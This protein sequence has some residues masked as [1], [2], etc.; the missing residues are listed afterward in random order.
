MRQFQQIVFDGFVYGTD[1]VYSDAAYNDLVGSVNQ[2]GIHA[3]ASEIS[4]TSPTLTVDVETSSNQ[5]NWHSKF[6][7]SKPINA[8][9][10]TAATGRSHYG[11]D[12]GSS[13]SL[14]F[15]RLAISLGG[16]TPTA[17]LKIAVCGRSSG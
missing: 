2:L 7:T 16:T 14:G 9:S 13:P 15:C 4:G 6:A 5:L 3:L 17:R 1:T 10:L 8:A 11:Q 12:T